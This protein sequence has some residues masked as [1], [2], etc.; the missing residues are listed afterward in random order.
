[1]TFILKDMMKVTLFALLGVFALGVFH[2][3]A[4]EAYVSDEGYITMSGRVDFVSSDEFTM[5]SNDERIDVTMDGMD[6]DVIERL[7]ES[8]IIKRD[9]Y[10]TVTGELNDD[11]GG[12]E[13]E[14]SSIDVNSGTNYDDDFIY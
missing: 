12:L 11:V 10:V 2:A 3:N 1:M 13:I 9:A 6:E 7:I 4:Q 14:A 5:V 8:D